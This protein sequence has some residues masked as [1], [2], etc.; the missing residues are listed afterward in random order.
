MQLLQKF[1]EKKNK[2]NK[3][4][5]APEILDAFFVLRN[6][7]KDSP[8]LFSCPCT[9]PFSNNSSL[10]FFLSGS[11]VCLE[12]PPGGHTYSPLN[13]HLIHIPLNTLWFDY[14]PLHITLIAASEAPL[15]LTLSK[16]SPCSLQLT[17][18]TQLLKQL[19]N[20]AFKRGCTIIT[21][22]STIITPL[23]FN[24]NNT[25]FSNF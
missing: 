16:A 8:S 15:G 9:Y 6:K 17:P 23:D 13:L 7:L 1:L 3:Q 11:T 4:T 20:P 19:P 21:L 25:Q 2:Q 22:F 24:Q 12:E 5:Y 10:F 14:C 18:P